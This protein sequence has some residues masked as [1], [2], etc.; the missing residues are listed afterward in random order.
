MLQSQNSP[1]DESALQQCRTSL[2]SAVLTT[3]VVTTA[4]VTSRVSDRIERHS[5]Q[6][7]AHD[8]ETLSET[9]YLSSISS[10]SSNV[11]TV[12]VWTE[13]DSDSSSRHTV[14]SRMMEVRDCF[15]R[16]SLY[17]ARYIC[18]CYTSLGS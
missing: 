18:Y 12:T 1:S 6:C 14:M 5:I 3:A 9:V 11:T 13:I 4:V 2:P 15:Y 10:S 16:A 7:D 17:K 8:C